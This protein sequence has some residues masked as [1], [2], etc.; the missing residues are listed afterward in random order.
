MQLI[1]PQV[2][3]F[4]SRDGLIFWLFDALRVK[5]QHLLEDVLF[6][7][8]YQPL[9]AAKVPHWQWLSRA[10]VITAG[11]QFPLCWQSVQQLPED[12]C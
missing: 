9:G 5:L 1:N 12:V 3:I 8:H 6:M 7:R 4:Q 11:L 10:S 2:A